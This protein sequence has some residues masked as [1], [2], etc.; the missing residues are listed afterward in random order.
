MLTWHAKLHNASSM[1]HPTL[2][3]LANFQ[4]EANGR[5][6]SWIEVSHPKYFW[7]FW[8]FRANSITGEAE[9][10]P[11]DYYGWTLVAVGHWS[12]L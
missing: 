3:G 11:L 1:V 4:P 7:S 12:L 8:K 2:F 10:H 6:S 9:Q 5:L